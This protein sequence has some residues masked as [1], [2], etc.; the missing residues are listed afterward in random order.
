M[1][2]RKESV[3]FSLDRSSLEDPVCRLPVSD[4]PM[5]NMI[6][7]FF[8]IFSENWGVGI[9]GPVWI[10]QH[11]KDLIVPFAPVRGIGC[12][13]TLFGPH[14]R[15]LLSVKPC[16]PGRQGHL[17]VMEQSRDPGESR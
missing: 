13:V 9:T 3:Q 10:H 14:A 11:R 12:S 2:T 6:G 5:K 15:E 4:F 7:L 8:S 1:A 17:L 16:F